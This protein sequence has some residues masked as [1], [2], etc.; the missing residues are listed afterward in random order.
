MIVIQ[1]L[2]ALAALLALGGLIC[3]LNALSWRTHQPSVVAMHLGLAVADLWALQCAVTDQ[4]NPGAIGIVVA[5]LS[6][7]WMSL[8]TWVD[9]PPPHTEAHGLP[10]AERHAELRSIV[11]EKRGLR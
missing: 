10:L 4:V 2:V 6:W 5:A 11:S 8:R 3:R 9:G 1:V 7:L